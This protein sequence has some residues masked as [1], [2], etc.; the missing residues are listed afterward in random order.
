MPREKI[1]LAFSLAI[2]AGFIDAVGYLTLNHLFTA[3]MSGNS[4][5]LGVFL[6]HGELSMALPL[7]IVV[8]LFIGGIA[9][10]TVASELAM[11]RGVRSIGAI[12]LGFEAALLAVFMTYG[13]TLI[14]PG[15]SVSDH[16]PSGFYLLA[17]L[18]IVAMGVQTCVLRHI[19]GQSVRTT[20]VS[21]VLM[22]LTQESIN[23]LFWLGDGDR[24][25]KKSYLSDIAGFGSRRESALQVMILGGIWC[26]YLAGG[27]LG[28]Y[29]DSLW[30][31]WSLGVPLAVLALGIAAD[32]KRPVHAVAKNDQ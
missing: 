16:S 2:V 17:A 12:L 29:T 8:V 26:F 21:S 25:D 30:R 19:A 6:G 27:V 15:G 18:A 1:W 3:H 10:G 7:A 28:S 20:Y 5:K 14:G 4:D 32:L 24:R 11:R 31:L 23:Y 13:S 9:L 22:N